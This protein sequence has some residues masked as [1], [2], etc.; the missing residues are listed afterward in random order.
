M[1]IGNIKN[2]LLD[3]FNIERVMTEEEVKEELSI[4]TRQR[5]A[6]T[7]AVGVVGLGLY[8]I[9]VIISPMVDS[10]I[11]GMSSTLKSTTSQISKSNINMPY[12]CNFPTS[13]LYIG[14][15]I[16]ILML[17]GVVVAKDIMEKKSLE[18]TF[19]DGLTVLAPAILWVV[20]GAIL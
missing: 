13:R 15:S 8:K 3:A 1:E 7:L 6:Q 17:V 4:L 20:M 2:K 10:V 16:M 11:K 9:S 14:G 12:V 5:I 19:V 18:E